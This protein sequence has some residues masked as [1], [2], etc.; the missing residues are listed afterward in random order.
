MSRTYKGMGMDH[1]NRL[2]PTL[3]RTCRVIACETRLQLLWFLFEEGECCVS[4]LAESIHITPSNATIQLRAMSARGLIRYRRS[5]L[6]VIYR[7]EASPEVDYAIGLLEAL[8]V[9]HYSNTPHRTVMKQATAFTH[10]RRIEIVRLLHGNPMKPAA[11]QAATGMSSSAMMRHL[12]KLLSRRFVRES[13]GRYRLEWPGH[14][15][16]RTLM[17]MVCSDAVEAGRSPTAERCPP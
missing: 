3:W 13:E 9:C 7:A 1:M 11:L 4:Q 14:P 15:F 8:R 17:R 2:R 12:D 16:G 6:N 5:K 10:E